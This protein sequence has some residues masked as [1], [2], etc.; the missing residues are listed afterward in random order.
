MLDLDFFHPLCNIGCHRAYTAF[1]QV[2][3]E[4]QQFICCGKITFGCMIHLV[5]EVDFFFIAIENSCC[6]SK[7]VT[8]MNLFDVGDVHIGNKSR[9]IGARLVIMRELEEIEHS[10]RRVIEC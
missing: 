7:R 5:P 3:V 4:G 9:Y 8:L 10:V 2:D 1:G 6:K